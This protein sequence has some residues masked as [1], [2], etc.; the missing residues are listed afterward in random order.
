MSAF[1]KVQHAWLLSPGTIVSFHCGAC[2][3]EHSVRLPIEVPIPPGTMVH[4]DGP[5]AGAPK[6]FGP[7]SSSPTR[8]R[9]GSCAPAGAPPTELAPKEVTGAGVSFPRNLYEEGVNASREKLERAVT[10]G[11]S[12]ASELEAID[13]V[14]D[15]MRF[16]AEDHMRATRACVESRRR[17][18]ERYDAES[19]RL[20]AESKA[21]VDAARKARVDW[22]LSLD[23]GLLYDPTNPEDRKH[24][25]ALRA[26]EDADAWV[27]SQRLT[28]RSGLEERFAAAA[29]A[30]LEAGRAFLLVNADRRNDLRAVHRGGETARTLLAHYGAPSKNGGA[31]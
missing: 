13:G 20:L 23:S 9:P 2:A 17:D 12:A 24:D 15:E 1:R 29:G 21:K 28:G 3:A 8:L 7:I 30:A 27:L 5:A 11:E 16:L 22:R 31:A 14:V 19:E 18:L 10:M 6:F 26:A 25:E 4:T